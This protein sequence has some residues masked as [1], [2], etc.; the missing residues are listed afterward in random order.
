M[1]TNR[2]VLNILLAPSS[3]ARQRYEMCVS[4]FAIGK[5]HEDCKFAPMKGSSTSASYTRFARL[6]SSILC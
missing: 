2:H 4:P 5:N 1:M 3:A 6:G